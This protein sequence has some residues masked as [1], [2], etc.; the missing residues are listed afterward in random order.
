MLGSLNRLSNDLSS[1]RRQYAQT[2][3]QI[4]NEEIVQRD[5]I[6]NPDRTSD[7]SIKLRQM[8]QDFDHRRP[9]YFVKVVHFSLLQ[10]F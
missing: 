3:K 2:A 5:G 9:K 4:P 1:L 8:R 6:D 10:L 7:R